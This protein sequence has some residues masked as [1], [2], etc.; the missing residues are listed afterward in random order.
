MAFSVRLSVCMFVHMYVCMV[1]IPLIPIIKSCARRKGNIFERP[2]MFSHGVF[3]REDS[4]TL[5]SFDKEQ[6]N[7][8]VHGVITQ[9]SPVKPAKSDA[10]YFDGTLTDGCVSTGS[11]CVSK[12]DWPTSTAARTPYPFR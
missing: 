1:R 5:V 4:E 11:I 10:I 8:E 3:Q 6:T 9:L 12:R 7:A 2:T